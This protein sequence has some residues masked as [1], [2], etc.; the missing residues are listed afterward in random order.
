MT[1]ASEDP[2]GELDP[3]PP[4]PELREFGIATTPAFVDGVQARVDRHETIASSVELPMSGFTGVI[5]M[6]M[7]FILD[8]L[9]GSQHPGEDVD[10][11]DS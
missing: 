10:G 6:Y 5:R 9:S 8:L 2:E 1:H 4:I 3:G 7:L 11:T